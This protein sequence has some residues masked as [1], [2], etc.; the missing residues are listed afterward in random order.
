MLAQLDAGSVVLR[1]VKRSLVE[2]PAAAYQV[3]LSSRRPSTK[4]MF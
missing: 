4:L 1:A 2:G 3:R